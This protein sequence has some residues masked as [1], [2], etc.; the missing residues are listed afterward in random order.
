LPPA[1]CHLSLPHLTKIIFSCDLDHK[2]ITTMKIILGHN[3]KP[4]FMNINKV[5]AIA[6]FAFLYFVPFRILF[7]TDEIVQGGKF[8]Y[9]LLINVIGFFIAFGIGTNEPFGKKKDLRKV[10]KKEEVAQQRQAA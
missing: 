5:I 10:V 7:F 1:P 2:K 8:I 4:N 6:I 9:L 3:L